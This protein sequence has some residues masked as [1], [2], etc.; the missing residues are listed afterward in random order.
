LGKYESMAMWQIYGSLGFGVTL[1]SSVSRYRRAV[2][3][4]LPNEQF[5]VGKV[6]YHPSLEEVPQIQL[7]FRQGP[8]SLPGRELWP[9]ILE[10][11]FHKR[12]CYKY[13]NEWRAALYQ[14]RRPG[15]GIEGVHQAFDLEQLISAVDVGPRAN[16]F[17]F[18]A[19]KSI[20]DKF[21]LRKPL[22]PSQLLIPP[23][24]ETAGA[25]N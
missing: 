2:R 14:D 9:K 23:K 17:I 10:T 16:E 19:V 11:G 18:E 4:N 20:M 1:M 15:P 6:T 13:E 24:K 12:S 7:D 22:K 8:I 3:F 5:R 25:P 21:S